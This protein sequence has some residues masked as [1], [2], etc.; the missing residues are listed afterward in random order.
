MGKRR[1]QQVAPNDYQDFQTWTNEAIANAG[2]TA[3]DPAVTNTLEQWQQVEAPNQAL[4]GTVLREFRQ[5]ERRF[6]D[7]ATKLDDTVSK[8]TQRRSNR[9]RRLYDELN[10]CL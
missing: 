3:N 5:A 8:T 10:V 1:P 6:N 9:T 4:I 7:A 2:L